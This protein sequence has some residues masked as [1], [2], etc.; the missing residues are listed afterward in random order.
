M[1]C[2]CFFVFCFTGGKHQHDWYDGHMPHAPPK[3]HRKNKWERAGAK[4]ASVGRIYIYV[5][6]SHA[7]NVSGPRPGETA[8]QTNYRTEE[9]LGFEKQ[10]T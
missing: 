6:F 4:E 10:R 8:P 7:A 3:E 1:M 9:P 2:V 5:Y